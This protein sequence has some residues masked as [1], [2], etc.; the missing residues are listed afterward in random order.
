MPGIFLKKMTEISA[1]KVMELR[2][3]TGVSMMACKKALVQAAGDDEKAIEILRKSGAAKAAKKTDRETSE[4]AVTA[5]GR[6]IVKILCETDFVAKNEEFLKF[7]NEVAQIA[8]A[9]NAAAAE[10]F[11]DEK[12]SE[13]I[14]KL[15]ENFSFGEVKK[16]ESGEVVG[17]FVHFNNKIAAVV[18]LSGGDE[19]TAREI[20]MHAVAQNPAVLS[21]A[22]FDAEILEKEKEIWRAELENSG[23]P[24]EI[25]DKILIGKEKK[26]RE[27]NSLISQP[28]F[29]DDKVL[30]GE[31][32]KK[33]GGEVVEFARVAI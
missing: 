33:A 23:K 30:I 9:E 2:A 6:T 18:A 10:K 32:A 26:L 15:G 29:K 25:I 8:D 17:S 28:F 31:F 5:S 24:A 3:R 7:L 4:G 1:K 19:N 11:F 13:L 21:P 12:K 27:E 14:Q 20:A 16:V 22:D